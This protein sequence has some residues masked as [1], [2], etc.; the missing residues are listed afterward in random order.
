MRAYEGGQSAMNGL[1]YVRDGAYAIVSQGLGEV[2][3]SFAMTNIKPKEDVELPTQII[4][5]NEFVWQCKSVFGFGMA[6]V[7]LPTYARVH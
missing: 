5:S 7:Y 2:Q 4:L 1:E 3:W 6:E